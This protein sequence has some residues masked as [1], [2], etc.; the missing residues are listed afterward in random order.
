MNCQKVEQHAMR[1]SVALLV[2]LLL[3][4]CS[5]SN[6]IGP[7]NQLEVN[8]AT[9]N[10]QY[11]VS[12]MDNITQDFSYLWENT[13]TQATIDISQAMT[14]GSAVLTIIDDA[15]TVV[16]QE[17]LRDDND[18]DTSVGIAGNWSIDLQ[19]NGASGTLNFRVQRRT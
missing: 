9:D 18:T 10:F 15:G 12:N 13:G 8:N 16:H 17:D 7:D 14:A 2:P 19:L 4:A 1:T 11:Q 5:S 6:L 3:I